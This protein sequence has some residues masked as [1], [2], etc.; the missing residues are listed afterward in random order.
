MEAYNERH[1]DVI[2]AAQAVKKGLV[3]RGLAQPPAVRAPQL[4]LTRLPPDVQQLST[5]FGSK[6]MVLI[7]G[8]RD[9]APDACLPAASAA[10]ATYMQQPPA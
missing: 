4:R 6:R 7:S 2:A 9:A 5:S 3:A 10:R 1:L 8:A